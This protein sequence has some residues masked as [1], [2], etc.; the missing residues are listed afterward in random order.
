MTEEQKEREGGSQAAGF[1]HNEE[2]ALWRQRYGTECCYEQTPYLCT[3]HEAGSRKLGEPGSL[4]Y[5]NRKIS[6]KLQTH[7][8]PHPTNPGSN[9]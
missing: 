6:L 3:K 2:T 5:S 1:C 4:R 9:T 8:Q 7:H